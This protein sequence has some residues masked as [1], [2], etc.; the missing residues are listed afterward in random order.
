MPYKNAE[1]K[2]KNNQLWRKN[3]PGYIS[4][5][6]KKWNKA[7][8]E[9]IKNWVME[10]PGYMKKVMERFN[11]KHPGYCKKYMKKN[12]I[13]YYS[14]KKMIGAEQARWA[15]KGAIKSS[16]LLSLSKNF[17]SCV[18]CGDQA[19]QYDHRDYN[20]PLK[21]KPVCRSCN[22]KRGKAIPIL[23]EATC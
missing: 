22:R 4:N 19:I 23:K 3:H 18:D 14:K 2:R 11:K 13:L 8:P 15:V 20:K 16:K 5:Y 9:Y 6:M 17:I 12:Y 10:H 7:H 1:D 21:V